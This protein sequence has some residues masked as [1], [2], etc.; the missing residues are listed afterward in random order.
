MGGGERSQIEGRDVAF[1]AN[2]AHE[3]QGGQAAPIL[4]PDDDLR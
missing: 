2:P 3:A 1:H 4:E